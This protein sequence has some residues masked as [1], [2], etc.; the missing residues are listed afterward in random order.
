MLLQSLFELMTVG[1]TMSEVLYSGDSMV[2]KFKPTSQLLPYVRVILQDDD[3]GEEAGCDYELAE[4]LEEI[5]KSFL[6][7]AERLRR[8]LDQ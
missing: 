8:I 3:G 6:V 1:G 4:D 5:G 2:I 7:A